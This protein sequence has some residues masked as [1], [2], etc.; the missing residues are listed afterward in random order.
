[1][2]LPCMALGTVAI[3]VLYSRS[4]YAWPTMLA[5]ALV[6]VGNNTADFQLADLARDLRFVSTAVAVCGC[7][8]PALVLV[9]A[10]GSSAPRCSPR[11]LSSS[12]PPRRS[13]VDGPG[14][15]RAR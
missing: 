5:I 15:G 14:C 8:I 9:A 7:K 4:G 2:T 11:R 3:G 6:A 12:S 13:S 10:G 1:M